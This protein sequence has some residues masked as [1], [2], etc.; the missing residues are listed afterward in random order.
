M[1]SGG[2]ADAGPAGAREQRHVLEV[3]RAA[4]MR[5]IGP[6]CLGLLNN[7]RHVRL[8]A[9]YAPTAPQPG[10]V[11]MLSLSGG[12]GIALLERASALGIGVSTF[13]SVGNRSSV[14]S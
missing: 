10:K 12:L 8:D 4:G 2:F 1:L 5:V 14:R 13:V 6:N 7:D 9:T 3:A 11:A